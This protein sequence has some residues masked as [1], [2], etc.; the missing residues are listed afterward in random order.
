MKGG[1]RDSSGH[2]APDPGS[3]APSPLP[4][5]S[6]LREFLQ[7]AGSSEL[8]L[9][10]HRWVLF[11]QG[12]M[13]PWREVILPF[14]ELRLPLQWTPGLPCIPSRSTDP[15]LGC[16]NWGKE[17]WSASACRSRDRLAL[18]ARALRAGSSGGVGSTGT[19]DLRDKQLW[20][21][22]GAHGGPV[23]DARPRGLGGL[24]SSGV[25]RASIDPHLLVTVSPLG[26][27][28]CD[29]SCFWDSF[30]PQEHRDA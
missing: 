14:S 24:D 23:E 11:S 10:C 22:Q 1:R 15:E 18:Q 5:P 21:G 8:S 28:P 20:S 3:L 30:F 7:A 2:C 29:I 25:P 9:L 4:A 16:G 27:D 13:S 17:P 6:Q 19:R 26:W 12:T